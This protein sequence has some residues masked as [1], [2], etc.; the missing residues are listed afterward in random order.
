MTKVS[1]WWAYLAIALFAIAMFVSILVAHRNTE[2]AI[3]QG[4]R[5]QELADEGGDKNA[6][7]IIAMV[8]TDPPRH[9]KVEWRAISA[10]GEIGSSKALPFLKRKFYEGEP[11][12]TRE[13]A[14]MAIGEIG[15]KEAVNFLIEHLA[16]QN[17]K[18]FY[19]A[20]QGLSCCRHPKAA[21]VLE[22]VAQKATTPERR[23]EAASALETLRKEE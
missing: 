1:I 12:V 16:N 22:K 10:L 13:L 9:F 2:L 18:I 17:D 6:L 11:P 7:R 5:I 15:T 3:E 20:C 23:K 8:D 14:A 19:Y 21:T 4:K